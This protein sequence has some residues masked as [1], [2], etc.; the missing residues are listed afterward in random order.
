M[1]SGKRLSC[2]LLTNGFQVNLK[3][4]F[5]VD[6][7]YFYFILDGHTTCVYLS[8][9]TCIFYS[10]IVSILLQNSTRDTSYHKAQIFCVITEAPTRHVNSKQNVILPLL[11]QF[12]IV[13]NLLMLG[14]ALA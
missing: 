1:N 13:I 7:E 10:G 6:Y 12:Y 2:H 3:T 9:Q 5:C 11:H 14:I 4:L 8:I